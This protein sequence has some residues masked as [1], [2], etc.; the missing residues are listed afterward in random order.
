MKPEMATQF[1][2]LILT[3][4]SIS[5]GSSPLCTPPAVFAE[6]MAW[7]AGH[8]GRVLPLAT[9]VRLLEEK[10][11][12]PPKSVVLTFDDAFR[13]FY[14]AA[15]PVLQRWRLPATV[16]VVTSYSGHTNRWPGQPAWCEE[17]P[18]MTWQEIRAVV[19][20]GIEVGCHSR[21]HPVLPNLEGEALRQEV[22]AGRAELESQVGRTVESFC[23]PYGKWSE[24]V[25]NLVGQHFRSACTTEMARI[26]S[27]PDLYCLPRI[28]AYYLRRLVFFRSLFSRP[29]AFYLGLRS[30]L[31]ALRS[32]IG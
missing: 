21:T 7:L 4:H 24:P 2:P 5:E 30:C 10:Q 31:R 15:L 32:H 29:G 9:L 22:L 23:Y 18:L 27:K 12:V 14:Q 13:N 16:F 20:Q 11:E 28:D 17:M 19:G 6:Q 8:A 1:R 26:D 3:Y 25:R